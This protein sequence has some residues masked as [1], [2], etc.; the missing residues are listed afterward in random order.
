M[1]RGYEQAHFVQIEYEAF[2]S[3]IGPIGPSLN[4]LFIFSQITIPDKLKDWIWLGNDLQFQATKSRVTVKESLLTVL[5]TRW[6]GYHWNKQAQA[7]IDA[8]QDLIKSTA[9]STGIK[10]SHHN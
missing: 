2:F 7:A 10:D 1:L 8:K 9:I 3:T 6:N 4:N 5:D